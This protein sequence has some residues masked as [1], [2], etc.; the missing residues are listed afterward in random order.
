MI[1]KKF[2]LLI[3]ELQMITTV[4]KT[5]LW[6]TRK[7]GMASKLDAIASE[8]GA[9]GFATTINFQLEFHATGI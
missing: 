7:S 5:S 9:L 6:S 3:S 2:H 8:F 4:L 1:G